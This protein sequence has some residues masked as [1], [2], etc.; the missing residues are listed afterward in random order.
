MIMEALSPRSTNILPKPKTDLPKKENNLKDAQSRGTA[1]SKYHALPPP[2]LVCEPTSNGE[3]Y[4]TGKFLGKG[5]FAIC[6]EGRLV[7]SD[8]VLAMKV[9]KSEMN[10]R[11]MEEKV[12]SD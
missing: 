7:R 10:Q 12:L 4:L 6:Y 3:Q 1:P 9:V 8:R 2:P 11:K 5:G